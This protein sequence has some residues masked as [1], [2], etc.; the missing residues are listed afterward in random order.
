MKLIIEDDEGRR[1]VIPLFRDE[2]TIGR[3]AE[4]AVRLTEKNVSRK[5]GKLVRENGGFFIEDVG[6]FTGI[7]VNG[8]KVHGRHA[9]GEGDLIEISEYDLTL[10][11]AP[12]A[13]R[14][15]EGSFTERTAP[16]G[17]GTDAKPGPA[18]MGPAASRDAAV[19]ARHPRGPAI[20][21]AAVLIALIAAAA[22]R[23]RRDDGVVEV[24]SDRAAVQR[25]LQAADEAIAAHRYSEA[26][27]FLE[28]ARGT[29]AAA[30]ELGALN[31]TQ[32]EADAERRYGELEAALAAR[33]VARARAIL[34]PLAGTRTYWG[35]QAAQKAQQLRALQAG[36][37]A[38][39]ATPLAASSLAPRGD[40][41]AGAKRLLEEGNRQLAAQDYA[42][43]VETFQRALS[44]RPTG[45]VLANLYRSLGIGYT[46]QGK[47][48]EG[49]RYY[50]LYLP[51]CTNPQERRYLEKTLEKYDHHRR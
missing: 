10:Q 24:K 33:D 29:G 27:Q 23:L 51:L 22:L 41:D 6:S 13:A 48:D 4:S 39:A 14:L 43:A 46:R 38:P 42:G 2:L 19:R 40:P 35:A 7:R 15:E 1:T 45:A 12:R 34:E 5:H 11:D 32:D 3:S 17:G 28:V 49:A 16:G 50:R 37:A 8:E 31:R 30:Q 18:G 36:D 47:R 21:S 25:A 26:A 9:V 20:A 44:L